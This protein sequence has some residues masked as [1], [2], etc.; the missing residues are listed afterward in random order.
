MNDHGLLVITFVQRLGA[1]S[2]IRLSLGCCGSFLS[3]SNAL[4]VALADG[5]IILFRPLHGVSACKRML[6]GITPA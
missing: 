6:G 1:S 2:P 5:A 4:L 3:L